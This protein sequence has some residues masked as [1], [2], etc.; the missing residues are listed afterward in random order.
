[1]HLSRDVLKS[2]ILSDNLLANFADLDAQLTANG[3]DVRL[4]AIVEILEGG[5]LGAQKSDNRP[6]LLGNAVVL[7]GFESRLDGYAVKMKHVVDQATVKLKPLQP[8]LVVTCEELNTP[9]HLMTHIAARTSLFRLA[10]SGLFCT[11]GEA[12]YKGFLT[13]MLLPFA[14]SE[15]DLGAR[16]AQLT[17]SELKGAANY[18]DQ[19]EASY[20]GG[21]LF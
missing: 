21:K 4:A 13:F 20:Q 12:G 11:F 9:S 18:A 1:M 7:A 2:L 8:Y 17:F 15:I 3:V 14:Q 19:K 16:F 5:R 10:Q 6:P